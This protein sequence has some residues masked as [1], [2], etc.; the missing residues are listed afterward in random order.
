MKRFL[1][2]VFAIGAVMPTPSRAQWSTTHEQFY[3]PGSFN[4][5]FRRN[6]PGADRLF[7][8]FDYGHAVLYERLLADQPDVRRR[9]EENEFRYLTLDLL[10]RPPRFA[11]AEEVI[12]PSYAKLAW[13]AKQMFGWAHVLQPD[14][15]CLR[16]RTDR[17]RRQGQS[18][19][20]V[21][22]LLPRRPG[23]CL[24]RGPQVDG[25]HG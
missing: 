2:Y 24:P 20:A 16:R 21:D 15:R 19:R 4:W 8:A 7:N 3:L 23:D 9:L 1:L 17:A 5:E 6:Y 11:V 10:R 25:T 18:D 22:R 13:R 12:E 14:L